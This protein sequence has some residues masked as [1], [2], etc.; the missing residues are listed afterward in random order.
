MKI[1]DKINEIIMSI[2]LTEFGS[3]I[4]EID[5]DKLFTIIV[6]FLISIPLLPEGSQIT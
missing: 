4:R 1:V 5:E 6:W 2:N 3:F